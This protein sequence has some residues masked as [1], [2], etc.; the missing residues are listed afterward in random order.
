MLIILIQLLLLSSTPQQFEWVRFEMNQRTNHAG[1]TSSTDAIIYFSK[2]SD[3]LIHHIAPMDMY[4]KNNREGE[5]QIYNPGENSYY[6][7]LNF[8]LNSENNQFYFFLMNKTSNMGLEALGFSLEET[9]IDEDLLISIYDSSPEVKQYFDKVELVHK[10]RRPI[11]IG[12]MD[13]KGKY[14]KKVFYYDYKSME[15]IDF[16]NSITEIN[17]LETKDSIISKTK[18]SNFMFDRELDREMLEFEIPES[19]ILV[20]R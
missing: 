12:Y 19:A 18:F 15:G 8:N 16:P 17:Y 5:L 7:T 9:K 1:K 4:I 3:L 13:K 6:Q 14:L 2:K 20:N 11:F 10:G